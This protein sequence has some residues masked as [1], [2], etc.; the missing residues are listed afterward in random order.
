MPQKVVP[1]FSLTKHVENIKEEVNDAVSKIFQ[2]QEFIGSD[3]VL[4]FEKELSKY[5]ETT[6]AISCNSGTDALWLSLKALNIKKKSIV[7]TTPFSFIASTSEIVSH[8]AY[9]VFVDIDKETFNI[10]PKQIKNWL[11]QNAINQDGKT[12]HKQ[13][14]FVVEGIVTVDIFGQ[15]ANWPKIKAIA[16][17]WNL[18]IVE[19]ACQAIGAELNG[20]K[21]GNFGDI[22]CF[23]FYP[24]KNLGAF[25]DAGACVTNNLLLAERI[26]RIKNH[27]RKTH[28]HYEELG[29]NSRMDTIQAAILSVKLKNLDLYTQQRIKIANRYS[30]Q[31]KNVS[32]ITISQQFF[33]KHTYHQYPIITRSKKLRNEL[34]EHLMSKGIQTRIFY[35]EL[36]SNIN[37]LSCHEKLKTKTPMAQKTVDTILSLPIWPELELDSIDY[38]CEEIKNFYTRKNLPEYKEKD[39]YV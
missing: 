24:T 27:G 5:T 29:I 19:D 21:A 13:T 3:T 28:Y 14:G 8:G 4:K 22:A 16:N 12:V 17:K 31:L 34:I 2:T 15:C 30:N 18:W 20:K 37:F 32:A 33:G 10:C 1:F 26:R 39:A 23:S 11:E 9:P 25:G 38:V 6:Y 35:P 7:I 36:L